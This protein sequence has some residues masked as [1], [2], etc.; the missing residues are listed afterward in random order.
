MLEVADQ[1]VGGNTISRGRRDHFGF[2][3]YSMFTFVA[4]LAEPFTDLE[5][6]AYLNSGSIL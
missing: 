5:R 3:G 6:T 1:K 2:F 4:D